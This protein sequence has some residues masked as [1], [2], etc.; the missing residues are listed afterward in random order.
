M[1]KKLYKILLKLIHVIKQPQHRFFISLFL[2]F[3]IHTIVIFPYFP[4][5]EI[6]NKPQLISLTEV[7]LYKKP[8]PKKKI[9][10][11]II[12]KK[13][14]KPKPK[15]VKKPPKEIIEPEIEPTPV[16]DN[17]TNTK[18][19][20]PKIAIQRNW[21]G[22]CILELEVL[23]DGSVGNIKLLKTSG[24]KLLDQSAIRAVRFW[25]FTPATKKGKNIKS[26]LK[27]PI[28]F[29]LE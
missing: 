16:Y 18:P 21:Q 24:R 10:K 15:H 2:S 4:S 11:K 27:V 13:V 19:I 7:T 29:K 28:E 25:K 14:S 3:I 12:K 6:K 20:Y 26:K 1:L 22:T 23:N 17:L 5:K 8:P 9:I